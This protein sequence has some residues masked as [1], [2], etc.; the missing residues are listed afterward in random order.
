M[1]FDET[2]EYTEHPDDTLSERDKEVLLMFFNHMLNSLAEHRNDIHE[3]AVVYRFTF[4]DWHDPN[5]E[6]TLG[7]LNDD[8]EIGIYDYHT[9]YISKVWAIEQYRQFVN[10]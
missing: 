9:I 2:I 3:D 4:G 8:L 6:L 10:E 5:I 7:L 1:Q